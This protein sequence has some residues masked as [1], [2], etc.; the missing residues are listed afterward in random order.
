M[1]Q[2]KKQRIPRC[3]KRK[4]Q[5]DMSSLAWLFKYYPDR[6]QKIAREMH[7]CTAKI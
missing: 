5:T 2:T 1:K 7:W 3:P 4:H 6:Y